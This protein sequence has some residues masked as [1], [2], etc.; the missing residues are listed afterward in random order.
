MLK[1]YC[2]IIFRNLWRNKL[3][4]AVNIISLGV[5]IASIIWGIQN[6]RYCFSYNDFHKDGQNIFRVLTKASGNDNRK[7]ICPGTLAIAVK[8]DFPVV[9]EA[10]RW[11]SRGLNV[12]ADQSE[13][14]ESQAHFTDPQFFDFFN[15]PLVRGTIRLNDLSTVLITQKAA[16]KFFGDTDPIG[17]TLMFYSDESFRKP[18][19]VTG[20]L[21]DPPLNSSFQFELITN[22]NNQVKLDGSPVKEEDWAWFSDAVFVKLSNPADA[23]KLSEGLKKYLPLEQ[24]AA[25]DFKLVS[26]SLQPLSQLA[27]GMFIDSN[28][29]YPRPQ[30][31]AAIGPLVLA[32]LILLSA[33][34]N[35]ANTSVAQ[36]NRRLK[37]MGVRKVMGSSLQQIIIQQLLECAFIVFLAIGLSIM[38]NNFWLPTFNSMFR[39]VHV[40]ANYLSDYTLLAF[41]GIILIGVTL[42][43]GAYP[44]FYISRFNAANIFGGSVKFGGTNLFSRVLL[45]LQVAISFITVIAGVAFSRNS[46]FQTKFDYGYEKAN[47]IGVNLQNESSYPAVRDELTKIPGIDKMA[48][49]VNNIGFSYNRIP[50][51]SKGEKK[52][53]IYLE[54]GDNYV[55][56]MRLK[57]V[58][59]RDFHMAGKA[60]YGK[61]MLVNE[62][63]AFEF[64]WKPADAIGKQIKRNDTTIYT[65]VGVLKDFTQATLF[66]PLQP[67]AMVLVSP[68]KY[69]RIIIRAKQGSVRSVFEQAKTAWEKLYPTK[70]FMGNFQDNIASEAS[71]VNESVATIFFWFAIISVLMAATSIF[72][73]V[74]LNVLKKSKE[75]AI[76]KVVGAG[77][78]HIF[79]LVLKGYFLI[80]LL[81]AGIG[82]Y[83]G[84]S[85]SKLLMDLIFR[86]NAGVSTSSL[87]IS[88]IGV[89]LICA[90]TIGVRVWIVLKTKVTDALKT[91]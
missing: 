47:V 28:A 51:E 59:G 86:I 73:L 35:F 10:L 71:S 3:F 70:P 63:L 23:V 85:L 22:T 45:G 62:K 13:P 89:M 34:L 81:A 48:G 37:E 5:G 24:S 74:S 25:R 54:T 41:M 87:T 18:L 68:E 14:F 9:K 44:A 40:T 61:S 77:D 90:G 11:D 52:E 12:K 20:I 58:A 82:C 78:W 19:T 21:K 38:I 76:R 83:G 56:V 43:A 80:F 64:G 32:I 39:F 55:D 42:L 8:N 27:E 67:L 15:F 69:S 17:K 6:Y 57:M 31:S 26:F 53:S 2:T 75:I 72:A 91:N 30:D 1:N 46:T 66:D 88:F 50:L 36:S 33:C 60:D 16:K 65:V 84:Y 7:G 79:R 49:T 4:T 29:L